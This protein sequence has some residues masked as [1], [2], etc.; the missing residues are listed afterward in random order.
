M[1]TFFQTAED[2]ATQRKW[3]VVDAAGIAVGRVASEVA[4]LIRGKDDPKYTPHVDGGKF[5]IVLNADKA[6]FT[7]KKATDKR[8]YRHTGFI[9]GIKET[10]AGHMLESNPE[11]VI[12][13]AVEG[14][15]PGGIL[16][17][18]MIGKLKV[19]RGEVHPHAAQGP[20]KHELRSKKAA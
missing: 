2:A 11:R 9:G 3:V 1:S 19:Y 8:Y 6:V 16:G 4:L 12:K 14:M 5:V 10:V 15:L 18:R 7:G 13:K 20:V 17:H